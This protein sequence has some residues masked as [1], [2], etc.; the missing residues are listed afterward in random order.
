VGYG[1]YPDDQPTTALRSTDAGATSMMPPMNPDD[2][3]DDRPDRRRQNQKKSSTSTILLVVAAVLVLVGAILIGK[4][5]FGNGGVG[6]DNVPVPNFVGLTEENAKKRAVNSDLKLTFESKPCEE[7]PKGRICD[8]NPDPDTEVKKNST[9]DLVVSTGAPKVAVPSVIGLSLEEAKAKLED[10]K[11]GFKVETE[12]KESPEEPGTVLEQ[13]PVTGQ[14]IEKGSTITLTI[15]KEEAKA[16]V[17]SVTGQ[18]CE[19]AQQQ[20]TAN[21]LTGTCTEVPTTDP[22][23]DGTVIDTTP[24]AGTSVDPGSTVTIKVG[25]LQKQKTKV[26]DVRNKTVAQA[27]QELAGA[28]FTNIQFAGGSDQSDTAL[29]IDQDPDG[30]NEVDNPGQ[31]TITLTTVGF[32]GGNNNGGGN[33]NGGGLFGGGDGD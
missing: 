31:T 21:N 14:E 25:K 15:A 23:Q 24:A 17:P 6:N 32:G 4:F 30:G 5:A 29:V 2:G 28:G 18:T 10:D 26:P 11:Y 20:M 8:Q 13:D 33:G 19:A 9:V 27:K 7:Q 16:T 3:Y 22:N 1:G 12:A